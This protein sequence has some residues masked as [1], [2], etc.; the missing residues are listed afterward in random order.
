[1]LRDFRAHGDELW[2]RFSVKDPQ[3]HLWY[4]CSLVEVYAQRI[5]NWM[6]DELHEVNR[7]AGASGQPIGLGCHTLL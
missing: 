5:D 6:V 2:Q 1:I 4:Y 7:R 3:Q